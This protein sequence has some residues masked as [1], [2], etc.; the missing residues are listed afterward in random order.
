MDRSL[1]N[2]HALADPDECVR[3]GN[4][5]DN[6]FFDSHSELTTNLSDIDAP[7]VFVGVLP[8]VHDL[9]VRPG[10][11]VRLRS[12]TTAP[13]ARTRSFGTIG[14][15]S[16]HVPAAAHTS[17]YC[18]KSGSTK[19]RNFVL[20]P[21]GG[22]P[23]LGLATSIR[24]VATW[25]HVV[26]EKRVCLRSSDSDVTSQTRMPRKTCTRSYR[27]LHLLHRRGWCYTARTRLASPTWC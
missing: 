25:P 13:R 5:M 7:L 18:N 10:C 2:L 21:K 17:S 6:S 11:H 22:T 1:H 3:D 14:N 27:S 19:I 26:G 23:R 20:C 15:T 4:H 24:S 8:R 16:F 12:V 9:S